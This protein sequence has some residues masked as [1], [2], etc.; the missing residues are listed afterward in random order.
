[1]QEKLLKSVESYTLLIVALLQDG[2]EEVRDE[3][4]ASV[5]VILSSISHTFGKLWST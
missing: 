2:D 4:A 1:M 3:M 5:G